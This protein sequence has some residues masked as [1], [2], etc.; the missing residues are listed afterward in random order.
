MMLAFVILSGASSEYRSL[1]TVA[2]CARW[3]LGG[4][5]APAF[6]F[7]TAVARDCT[8]VY[9]GPVDQG[10]AVGCARRYGLRKRVGDGGGGARL[11]HYAMVGAAGDV[12]ALLPLG[13][14]AFALRTSP[15]TAESKR[16]VRHIDRCG[17]DGSTSWMLRLRALIEVDARDAS[18]GDAARD[19][20]DMLY[21]AGL[22]VAAAWWPKDFVPAPLHSGK[23]IAVL[24]SGVLRS[25][26]LTAPNLRRNVLN[27]LEA[28]GHDVFVFAEASAYAAHRL[29]AIADVTTRAVLASFAAVNESVL[30]PPVAQSFVLERL[31]PGRLQVFLQ[32]L[33]YLKRVNEMCKVHEAF[34]LADG[35]RYAVVLYIREDALFAQKIPSQRRLVAM[36]ERVERQS[37]AQLAAYPTY[38]GKPVIFLPTFAMYPLNDRFAFGRPEAM[39]IFLGEF[40]LPLHFTRI[41]LTI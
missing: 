23:R 4:A 8:T 29:S 26:H 12:A 1:E 38:A 16:V 37:A 24:L 20:V 5:C 27:G 17:S 6:S 11:A 9:H 28:Q 14:V 10:G 34:A 19:A 40:Y 15:P 36:V 33:L 21:R 35:A 41:L 13:I 3:G 2:P 30:S 18:A 22:D 25:I 7:M 32:Q 31:Q 39:D